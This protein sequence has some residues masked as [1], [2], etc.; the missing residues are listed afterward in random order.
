MAGP[1]KAKQSK[2][3]RKRTTVIGSPVGAPEIPSGWQRAVGSGDFF[4]FDETGKSVSG[5]VRDIEMVNKKGRSN[6]LTLAD[7]EGN[8]VKL[9]Y[10]KG[11][12]DKFDKHG[13]EVG[14][15]V[16]ITLLGIVPLSGGRTFT[17]MDVMFKEPKKG[18]K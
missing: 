5:T 1:K 18:R 6:I 9:A 11:I 8:D 2:G 7:N 17:D 14:W 3:G 13:I 4:K 10:T 12:N 15:S 16:M